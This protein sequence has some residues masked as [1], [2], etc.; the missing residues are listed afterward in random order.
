MKRHPRTSRASGYGRFVE[1]FYPLLANKHVID[2]CLPPRQSAAV[3]DFMRQSILEEIDDQRGLS[4]EE[5][6]RGRIAGSGRLQATEFSCWISNAFRLNGG[7]SV[8]WEK[9]PRRFNTFPVLCMQKARTP[10]L[11]LGLLTMVADRRLYGDLRDICTR[12]VG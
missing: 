8:L 3:S 7:R 4:I 5:W 9:G 10:Y 6:H 12:I 11:L 1:Y 2:L